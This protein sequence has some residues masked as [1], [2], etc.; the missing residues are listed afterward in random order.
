MIMRTFAVAILFALAATGL[1]SAQIGNPLAEHNGGGC[2]H[3]NSTNCQNARKAFAEHHNG[4]YPEQWDNQ[5]YQGHKGRWVQGGKD[6]KWEG[7]NGE[8]YRKVHD[9]WQWI[10]HHDHHHDHDE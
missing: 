6:W 10:E 4:M 7:S 2:A 8:Q 3:N 1:A 9:K 5:F